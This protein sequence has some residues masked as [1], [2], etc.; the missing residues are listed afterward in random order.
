MARV[1]KRAGRRYL[2]ITYRRSTRSNVRTCSAEY[3][4]HTQTSLL[5]VW[6]L[7]SSSN[8]H[9]RTYTKLKRADKAGSGTGLAIHSKTC[10]QRPENVPVGQRQLLLGSSTDVPA[11]AKRF[12]TRHAIV[13]WIT[14]NNHSFRVVDQPG[15]SFG[16]LFR[17]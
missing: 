10:L 13:S 7:S 9:C 3:K 4:Q 11:E 16:V 8:S 15:V 5:I 1:Y 6:V 17:F 2:D 12:E 14:Q